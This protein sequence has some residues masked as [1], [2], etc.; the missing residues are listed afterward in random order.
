MQAKNNKKIYIKKKKKGWPTGSGKKKYDL[1]HGIQVIL[2]GC[3]FASL[4][5]FQ[6]Q[7]YRLISPS[8]S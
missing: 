7:I 4:H 6:N 2:E 3:I 5:I 8:L 1:Q